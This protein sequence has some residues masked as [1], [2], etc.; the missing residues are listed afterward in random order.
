M[1]INPIWSY[2]P[3]EPSVVSSPAQPDWYVGWLDGALRIWPPFEPTI[4]GVT[5]P[6][7]RSSRAS[8]LP[9]VLFTIVALWPW[10]DRKLTGDR[11][12]HH[13]LDWPWEQPVRAAAGAAILTLFAV[14]TLAGGNDVLAVFLDRAV[15]TLTRDLPVLVIVLP[16]P[17]RAR[18]VRPVPR[19]AAP[20]APDELAPD[21][22]T[23]G[24]SAAAAAAA[25]RP[26]G[27]ALRRSA[28]GGFEEV[29]A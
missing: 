16:D 8:S 13:L 21:D 5:L 3:F 12:V 10:I 23:A 4:L 20:A 29:E 11:G 17:R 22:A 26:R 15:E 7:G 27:V 1:Q 6:V 25:R 28:D 18:H 14:L 24:D 2:G 9:G 19:A